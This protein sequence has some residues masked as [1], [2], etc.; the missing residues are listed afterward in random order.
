MHQFE[1]LMLQN[2][3]INKNK[4]NYNYNYKKYLI[5]KLSE[6]NYYGDETYFTQGAFL[7]IVGLMYLNEDQII[8][9]YSIL[10]EYHLI[11]SMIENMAY[12]IDSIDGK[13]D[14]IY[15]IKYFSR[16]LEA[17]YIF[18]ILYKKDHIHKK[19]I[20]DLKILT[21]NIKSF[22]RNR[23]N[24]EI[25]DNAHHFDITAIRTTDDTIKTTVD[26][27]KTTIIQKLDSLIRLIFSKFNNTD[28]NSY[29][30]LL[31]ELLSG[32]INNTN[33]FIIMQIVDNIYTFS[34][35]KKKK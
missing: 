12:F 21:K 4:N 8:T 25:I 32:Y 20:E 24:K 5:N 31:L 19:R 28:T 15:S 2:T 1:Q 34:L 17:C 26:T 22:I 18:N 35:S 33:T 27:I 16:F 14:I 7:H 3:N 10:K 29:I 11:H 30:K 13:K 23:T 9:N 6:M